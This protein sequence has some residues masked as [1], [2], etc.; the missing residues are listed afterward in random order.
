V[1][2]ANGSAKKTRLDVKLAPAAVG[3]TPGRS[4]T[5][6]VE[7]AKPVR[8]APARRSGTLS[9]EVSLPPYAAGVFTLEP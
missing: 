9:F 7:G 3:Q 8:L 4:G 6:Y 5:L 1:T 2:L